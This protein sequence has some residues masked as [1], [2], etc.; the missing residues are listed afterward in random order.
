MT[1]RLKLLTMKKKTALPYRFYRIVHA[2]RIDKWFFEPHNLKRTHANAYRLFGQYLGIGP[3]SFRAY[4]K[5][6]SRPLSAYP[7]PPYIEFPLYLSVRLALMSSLT[8][9]NRTSE[10][11]RRIFD[12]TLVRAKQKP[13]VKQLTADAVLEALIE[14]VTELRQ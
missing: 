6:P 3:S 12:R 4:R 14:I 11:L 8:E 10:M 2:K 9:A 1:S 7:L 5:H 13:D